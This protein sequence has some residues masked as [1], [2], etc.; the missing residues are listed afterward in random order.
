MATA[1]ADVDRLQRRLASG[2]GFPSNLV[3]DLSRVSRALYRLQG[4]LTVSDKQPFEASSQLRL[5]RIIQN[6]YDV[7]DILDEL[8]DVSI[9]GRRFAGASVLWSQTVFSFSYSHSVL[10]CRMVK[11]MKKVRKSLDKASEDSFL[12]SLLHHRADGYRTC[13]QEVFDETAII[14]RDGDKKNLRALLLS[15][16]DENFSIIPIVGLGGLGKTVLAQL[17][18]SDKDVRRNFDLHIWVNLNMSYNLN[19]IASAI[20][21]EANRTE[22]GTSQV[23]EDIE[24]NPQ[25][26]MNCL[27]EVL[28]GKRC[29]IVLDG[30]WS[31]YEQELL[32]LKKILRGTENTKIIVTTSSENVAK[33]MH[34]VRPYK[35]GP[36]SEENCWTIFSQ[37]IFCGGRH[38]D[39]TQLGKQIINKCEGIPAVAHCLGSLVCDKGMSI[40]NDEKQDLWKLERQFPFQLNM[41]S[42]IKQIYYNM[43]SA[44]KSCL[45]HL[46]M[47]P[48]GSD[49]RM[50]NLI[51]QWAALGILGSTHG[52]LPVYSQGKKYIQELLSVFFL[53]APDKS[54]GTGLTY[55][56]ASKVLNMHNLVHEFARYVTSNDLFI[57]DGERKSNDSTEICSSRYAVLTRCNDESKIRKLFPTSVRAVC[58]K[59]CV[60]AKVIEKIFSALKHLH[61]LDLSRCLFLE[62]PSSI[63][64][65]THLRY[66]DI[67]SS[68]IQAL[69]DQMSSLQNLEALDLSE[70]CVQVLPDF[71]GTFQKLKYL[72]LQGCRDLHHL[73]SKLDD[74]KSLQ[75]LNL[76]CCPAAHQL[77]E[78][79]SAFQELRFLDISSCSEIQTLPES[80]S[81]LTNLEDLIL[82][83]CTRLKKLP[84][85]FGE[86]CFLQFLNVSSCCELEEV[87]ASL[88][89]LASLEVL[90]LSG[91]SRIQ[92]LPESFIE[93]AFLWILDL[94]GCVDLHMN[95]EMLPKDNLENLIVDGCLKIYAKPGWAVNFPKLHPQCLQT[96]DQQIQHLITERQDC[97]SHNEVEIGKEPNVPVHDETE[98]AMASQS[99][100]QTGI[101]ECTTKEIE[102][103][104]ACTSRNVPQHHTTPTE[105]P[106]LGI[107]N[108]KQSSEQ[109]Q[110]V[111]VQ[112][113]HQLHQSLSDTVDAA[114]NYMRLMAVVVEKLASLESFN[115]QEV[116]HPIASFNSSNTGAIGFA[117][118][119]LSKLQKHF[120]DVPDVAAKEDPEVHLGQ[121]SLRE[122]QVATDNFSNK[123]ILGRGGFGEVYKGRLADGS[124]VAIKRQKKE[125]TPG[126]REHQFQAEV[127][128][129]ST[130]VHRNLLRLR[131]FCMTPTERLLVYPYMAN[132]SIASRLRERPGSE[133]P[134]DW[135]T[136]RRIALGSAR[137]LSYLHDYCIPKIIHRDVKAAN[138]LLD[139]DFEAVVGDFGLAK[140][141]DYKH[142]CVTD[143]VS[144]T[145]GHVAPEYLSTGKFSEKTDV[146]GYGIMLLELVS[147]Q[148]VFD[149]THL[150]C[151]DNDN[152]LNW[153]KGL[154][155]E[156]KLE[157]LVD[158]DLKHNYD[159]VEVESLIQ[160]ALLCTQRDPTGR[161]KM[162]EVLT[163]LEGDGGLAERWEERLKVVEDQEVEQGADRTTDWIVDSTYKLRSVELSGPR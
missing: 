93:I 125:K 108:Q 47:F 75:H 15:N 43:P 79:I 64:Q 39:L 158:D 133:P 27:R 141:M 153:V 69:P 124:L 40:W 119:P 122:L 118:W 162:S 160:I 115:L 152:L 107:Y 96:C 57:M 18:F 88:G 113:L 138:I 86:L 114:P 41:F 91:C 147:G 31:T 144:G 54:S 45:H 137:G 3:A 12:F 142:T 4:V 111:L 71:V 103:L 95:L 44:L 83:K 36:L 157:N 67:S 9:R 161:P 6:V 28:H 21:S 139:E 148:R 42:S 121:F 61:V 8:E 143:A 109:A 94:A 146:F 85:S 123:N 90:I 11:K 34:T 151:D 14:G 163:M 58:L 110:E 116:I 17:I 106:L 48:K 50:E 149:L 132:G 19:S 60:G 140:L 35:L 26:I 32:H 52:S 101:S 56:S 84:E 89:K 154:L 155:K 37:R 81:R 74:V 145:F 97:P 77:L 99:C 78:S 70:T 33:L 5:R 2:H 63:Y 136:R 51:R 150:A 46:S 159:D 25:I 92:N 16:N 22:E 66:I 105:Q 104:S 1:G 20:I 55:A 117:C 62:I 10:H 80:F 134:L 30:L 65:L 120:S 129:L 24:D 76:S 87:P 126:G 130:V 13:D 23:K 135:Q 38:S 127:D 59:D 72:N 98:E 102:D 68:A 82:S 128:I 7:E 131:G 112:G 156:K 73:P 49:I 100:Q 53:K 29:L